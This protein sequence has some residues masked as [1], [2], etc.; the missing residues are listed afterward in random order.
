VSRGNAHFQSRQTFYSYRINRTG[1]V[2]S[3]VRNREAFIE[4][5]MAGAISIACVSNMVSIKNLICQ[6]IATARADEPDKLPW[7]DESNGE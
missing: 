4:S 3:C 5:G 1:V 2:S 6:K 7:K